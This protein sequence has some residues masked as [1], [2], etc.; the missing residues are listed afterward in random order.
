MDDQVH[1]D[2]DVE[3]EVAVEEPITGIVGPEAQHDVAV[4]GYSDCILQR[5]LAKVTMQ[6]TTSIQV[7]GMFQID[8][9]NV[10]VRGPTHS[11]H[12]ESVS[13]QVEGMTEI[14]LLY[15][16]DQNDLH[17]GVERNIHCVCAHAVLGAVRW[18]IV[19][20]TELLRRNVF[21]LRQKR[22]GR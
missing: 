10:G 17:Y 2:H 22:G 7:Q 9:L 18:S 11:D 14:R 16:V 21:N 8:L 1:S 20:V 4:I 19:S 13:V 12:V 5:W 3:H 15:L 6:Q